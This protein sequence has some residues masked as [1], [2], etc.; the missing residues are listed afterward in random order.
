MT[1]RTPQRRYRVADTTDLTRRLHAAGMTRQQLADYL[2]VHE[3]EIDLEELPDLPVRL[4]LDLARRL[5]LHPADIIVG[6]DDVFDRLRTAPRAQPEAGA[7]PRTDTDA[8]TV[9]CALAH[10]DQPL[11]PEDLAVALDWDYHRTHNALHHAEEHPDRRGAFV[12][13]RIPPAHYTLTPR[14]DLLTTAQQS[15]LSGEHGNV[16][17]QRDPLTHDE[18]ETLLHLARTR[19]VHPQRQAQFR[20]LLD[21]GYIERLPDG[22]YWLTEDV[23][24]SLRVGPDPDGPTP[25]TPRATSSGTTPY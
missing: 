1:P 11:S 18:A 9:V 17:T 16:R 21:A 6:A 12:V 25:N 2:G 14:L 8:R 4:W 22:A 15:R 10:S 19:Q 24:Y 7:D 20:A 13:R 3:H 5:D 23:A